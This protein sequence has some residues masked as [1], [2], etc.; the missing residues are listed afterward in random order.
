MPSEES[1]MLILKFGFHLEF[2]YVKN[3]FSC[4]VSWELRTKDPEDARENAYYLDHIALYCV[5]YNLINPQNN[6]NS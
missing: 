1:I 5:C 6:H 3:N 4:L 2:S